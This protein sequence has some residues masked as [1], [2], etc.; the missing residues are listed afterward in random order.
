MYKRIL[1]I[2]VSVL[3]LF[4][5]NVIKTISIL[6]SGEVDSDL[7]KDE[8]SFNYIAGLIII[9]VAI[10][11]EKH[12][13][14]F[15]TGAPCAIS[16]ELAR[17]LGV[18]AEFTVNS[19]DSKGNKEKTGFIEIDKIKIGET[20][21][22]MI[23]AAIIDFNVVQEMSCFD[24]DGIIGANLMQKAKWQ[25]NYNERKLAFA[26]K[27]NEF[28]ISDSSVF[29]D[30]TSSVTGTPLINI[31]GSG[32]VR[33][34][35]VNFDTGSN[36]SLNLSLKNYSDLLDVNKT[37]KTIK[38]YGS[39]SSGAYGSN[40]D[41]SYYI[42][43]EKLKAGNLELR[44]TIAEF[45]EN[46]DAILGNEILDNYIVTIDWDLNKIYLDRFR[47]IEQSTLETFG[48]KTK[49]GDHKLIAGFIYENSP[50]KE[51]GLEVG[52]QIISIDDF[53]Y[54]NISFQQYCDM[55]TGNAEW[56]NEKSISIKWKDSDG[57]KDSVI[58]KI[59]LF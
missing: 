5:C 10:N 53:T 49:M 46:D 31:S 12:N 20:N 36:G 23:G 21:F 34:S 14:I 52:D 58:N 30:F 56:K 32:N 25:I 43:L 42:K 16:S 47:E 39:S 33:F 35:D 57:I 37:Y 6:K 48:F 45:S 38:G 24:I 15:D 1:I 11:S 27:L 51:I 9:E 19:I 40:I 8:I 29:I 17:E 3:L 55:L 44:N 26:S 59:N 54:E 2:I 7:K 13:F 50:A 28:H 4:G 22:S 41:T 18:K